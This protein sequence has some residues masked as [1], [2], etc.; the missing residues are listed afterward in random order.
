[1]GLAI[2]GV[3]ANIVALLVFLSNQYS[4]GSSTF[5]D[6]ATAILAGLLAISVLGLVLAGAGKKKLGGTLVIIGSVPF[7]P[8]GLLGAIGGRRIIQS[9]THANDLDARRRAAGASASSSA[10]SS[11][12]VR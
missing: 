10:E 7:V 11:R 1:M 4:E 2:G 9:D 12:G 3:T 8:L 6:V 5:L